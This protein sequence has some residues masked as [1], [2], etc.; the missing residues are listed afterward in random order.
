MQQKQMLRQVCSGSARNGRIPF[1]VER[2]PCHRQRGFL[3]H[4]GN[5]REALTMKSYKPSVNT[6]KGRGFT[7]VELLV[8]IAIIALLMAM[9][10]PALRLAKEQARMLTCRNKLR[11]YGIIESMYLSDNEGRFPS[12]WYWLYS[13]GGDYKRTDEPD[14]PFWP[15]IKDKDINLCTSFRAFSQTMGEVAQYSYSANGWLGK[16]GYYK[17]KAA[18]SESEVRRHPAKVFTFSEENLWTIPG[19]SGWALNDNGLFIDVPPGARDTFATY[20]RAPK[21]DYNK[22]SANLVFLDGHCGVVE[23]E[24]QYDGGNYEMARAK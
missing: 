19:L 23:A 22:G 10:M 6:N 18:Y 20:H 17:D 7:L 13:D 21:G 2:V 11:Q 5:P 14:G 9:L 8:V 12:P 15:Y 1:T 3:R 4:W 24:E 16:P